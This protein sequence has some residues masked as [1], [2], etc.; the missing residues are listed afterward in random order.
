MTQL[1]P[2]E[3]T[4]S[5]LDSNVDF[6]VAISVFLNYLVLREFTYVEYMDRLK[7][8]D[9]I[10]RVEFSFKTERTALTLVFQDGLLLI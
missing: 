9:C 1:Y 5:L 6:K 4:E 3:N 10:K 7:S 8:G 2:S